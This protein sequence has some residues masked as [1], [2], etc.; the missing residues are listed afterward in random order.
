M[1]YRFVCLDAGFTTL[2]PRRTLA[3]SLRGVLAEHGREV[4][5]EAMHRAWQVADRWFWDDHRRADNDMS[6]MAVIASLQELP[7]IVLGQG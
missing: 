4:T 2:A 3:D 1:R 7:P 5:D 6:G